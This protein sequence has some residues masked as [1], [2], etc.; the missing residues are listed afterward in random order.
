MI[1]QKCLIMAAQRR[2]QSL[3]T[4]FV[5]DL[6]RERFERALTALQNVPRE[7]DKGNDAT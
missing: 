6:C 5:H 3:K 2:N 7:S 4:I 1:L